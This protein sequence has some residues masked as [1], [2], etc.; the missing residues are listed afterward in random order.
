[1]LTS[2][3]CLLIGISLESRVFVA[4]KGTDLNIKCE[5]K[6]PANHSED[7]L[8]CHSPRNKQIYQMDIPMTAGQP[9]VLNRIVMLKNLT[10]S[11]EYS[12]QYK[13]AKVYW[14]L[15]VRGECE[16]TR[17]CKEKMKLMS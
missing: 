8:K 14:F 12:C 4:F 3:L 15:R 16:K 10:I 5:L 17:G 13:T 9:E 2:M 7:A 11:G 1:M 6:I